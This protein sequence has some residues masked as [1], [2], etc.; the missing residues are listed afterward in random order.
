MF[1][2]V[3]NRHIGEIK[4]DAVT[5][6]DHT[7]ELSITENP[8]ESGAAI[9]DHAV[10]QPKSVTIVGVVVDHQNAS[11]LESLDFPYIRGATDFLNSLPFPVPIAN[12]TLQTIAKAER[13]ASQALGMLSVASDAL[14]SVRAIAPWL[15]DF[16]L[17]ELLGDFTGSEKV[18]KCYAD[19]LKTQ[20]SG[21]TINVQTG[22]QLYE[23]ML[24][25]SIGVS[26]TQDGSA[27]FTITCREVF[28]VETQA[29]KKSQNSATTTAGKNKS[30]R[31]ATQSAAKSQ[32]GNVTPKAEEPKFSSF[33]N[34]IFG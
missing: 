6:E 7:S 8:I 32:K 24:L 5:S 29:V 13:I 19:L 34:K 28:I 33:L 16:G 30:G 27:T 20:K 31:T 12:Q 25:Q 1:A 22:I 14:D 11:L 2:T 17:G 10:V 26:Q 21:E 23:N 9:A 15:P 4:F 3:S 18:K